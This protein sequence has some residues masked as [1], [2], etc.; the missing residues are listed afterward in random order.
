MANRGVHLM[1]GN[2]MNQL[3]PSYMALGN[4]LN[5]SVSNPFFGKI[6]TGTLS[7]PTVTLQRLLVPFPQ[8]T[9]VTGGYGNWIEIASV[10]PLALQSIAGGAALLP[11]VLTCAFLSLVPVAVFSPLRR[12]QP[13][14]T[15]QS[16]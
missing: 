1:G 13:R 16:G 3:H 11:T 5:S 15:S 7:T 8:F 12:S 10:W 4:Q 2:N 14:A 6:A 9:G